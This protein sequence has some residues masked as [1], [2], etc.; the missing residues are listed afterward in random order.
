LAAEG[1][2]RF[3]DV[4]ASDDHDKPVLIAGCVLSGRFSSTK[5]GASE[6]LPLFKVGDACREDFVLVA[7]TVPICRLSPIKTSRFGAA[8]PLKKGVGGIF[9]IGSN[10]SGET[11]GRQLAFKASNIE[12]AYT[13]LLRNY[14]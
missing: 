10:R 9:F 3:Q 12:L 2:R 5:P 4:V 1:I 11:F 7:G 6:R 14:S 8:P 13:C